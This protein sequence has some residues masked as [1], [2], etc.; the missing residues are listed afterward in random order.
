MV[1]SKNKQN[2]NNVILE[3]VTV[4]ESDMESWA[5]QQH[6]PY[7]SVDLILFFLSVN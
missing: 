3:I 6:V 2:V 7:T 4:N 1:N 5:K